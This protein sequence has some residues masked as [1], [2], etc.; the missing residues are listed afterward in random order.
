QEIDV[1]QAKT[2]VA[3][4]S[5]AHINFRVFTDGLLTE[6]HTMKPDGKRLTVGACRGVPQSYVLPSR[7]RE[8]GVGLRTSDLGLRTSDLGRQ[9][10]KTDFADVRRSP[11]G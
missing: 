8:S 3:R 1:G 6:V 7:I 2:S 11:G 9:P 10:R 5:T 4:L